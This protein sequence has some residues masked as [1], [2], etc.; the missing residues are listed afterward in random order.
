MT[1]TLLFDD[2]GDRTGGDRSAAFANGEAETFF[3]SDGIDHFNGQFRIVSR[4]NHLLAF[5]RRHRS[6]DV[7]SSEIELRAVSGEKRRVSAAFR[8]S[9]AEYRAL[10]FLMRS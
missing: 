1:L 10:E 9:Q 8:R 4:H 6:G 7:G 5:R 3:N 2:L